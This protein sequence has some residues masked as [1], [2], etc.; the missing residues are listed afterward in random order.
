[1]QGKDIAETSA[2]GLE[3]CRTASSEH[4]S[5]QFADP[6]IVHEAIEPLSEGQRLMVFL[7]APNICR[8]PLP[9]CGGWPLSNSPSPMWLQRLEWP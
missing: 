5:E 1:M 3:H 4:G 9:R 7:T 6:I 8:Q 2:A